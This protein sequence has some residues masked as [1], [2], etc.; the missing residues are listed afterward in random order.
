MKNKIKYESNLTFRKLRMEWLTYAIIN[1][2]II[3]ITQQFNKM[4]G[5]T[6]ISK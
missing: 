3:L 1:L 6:I 2:A 4:D 5:I